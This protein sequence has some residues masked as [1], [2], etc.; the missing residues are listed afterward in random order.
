[1]TLKF[2]MTWRNGFTN[3]ME[4]TGPPKSIHKRVQDYIDSLN[5]VVKYEIIGE[6]K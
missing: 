2:R 6:K 1:M 3:V 4:M 5:N